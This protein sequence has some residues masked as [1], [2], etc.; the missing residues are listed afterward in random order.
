MNYYDGNYRLATALAD[1]AKGHL[2]SYGIPVPDQPVYQ[3]HSTRP[4]LSDGGQA[5]RGFSYVTWLWDELTLNQAS[6]LRLLVETAL[7]ADTPLYLT[8]D[9]GWNGGSARNNWI[10]VSGRPIV[11]QITPQPR[12]SGWVVRNVELRVVNLTVENDPA[13]GL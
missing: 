12:A 3:D 9:K 8:I 4:Y 13:T 6:T 1:L 2:F 11:P 10:D 7:D 5:L